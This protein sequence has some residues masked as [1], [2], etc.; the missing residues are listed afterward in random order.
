MDDNEEEKMVFI[1]TLL[2]SYED[3]SIL[4]YALQESMLEYKCFERKPDIELDIQ[5]V[6]FT[7]DTDTPC[8]ICQENLSRESKCIK[9]DCN[10]WYHS[11]CLKEWA[12]YKPECCICRSKL[13]IVNRYE[14]QLKEM[15]VKELKELCRRYSL[16]LSG[17]KQVLIDRLLSYRSY[18]H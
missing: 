18:S 7:L 1:I 9:T 5:E 3:D 4:N 11:S 15:T 10:H 14:E 13:N 16:R 6:E 8:A 2:T 12:L 17:R